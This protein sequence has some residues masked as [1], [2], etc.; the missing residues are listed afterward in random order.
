MG[1]TGIS[2]YMA[3][4]SAPSSVPYMQP[5]LN[6]TVRGQLLRLFP[7]AAPTIF[8]ATSALY[9]ATIAL[10]VFVGWKYRHHENA[11]RLGA[12]G[13]IP[14]ALVASMHCHT[15]DLLLLVPTIIMIFNDSLI[16]FGQVW[17]LAVML[18]TIVFVLPVSIEIQH[19]Y[20]LKGGQFNPW[21]F[22]LLSLSAALFVYVWKKAPVANSEAARLTNSHSN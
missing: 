15:Y 12:L 7:N 16:P 5:E 18:G 17:K 3:L 1:T 13:F 21:F 9:L 10:G 8:T 19:N 22:L 2:N 20:L 14:L 4:V 6:P 11:L